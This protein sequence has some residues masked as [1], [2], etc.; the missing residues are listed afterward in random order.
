MK[1]TIKI[2]LSVHFIRKQK[3]KELDIQWKDHRIKKRDVT[4]ENMFL[5][6]RAGGIRS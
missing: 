2:K 3:V 6:V 5:V 4:G 1:S